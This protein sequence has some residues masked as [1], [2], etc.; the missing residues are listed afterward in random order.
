M[1]FVSTEVWDCVN[2]D[3]GDGTAKVDEFMH[4]KT[5]DTFIITSVMVF[6]R[7]RM[8]FVGTVPVARV[9]FLHHAYHAA[10]NFSGTDRCVLTSEM[11]L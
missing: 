6:G 11:V 8:S 1:E 10:H 9:S 4:Y 3:P 5:H 7:K 2:Y